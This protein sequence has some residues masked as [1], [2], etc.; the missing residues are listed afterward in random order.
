MLADLRT[1][2]VQSEVAPAIQSWHYVVELVSALKRPIG[3]ELKFLF[4]QSQQPEVSLSHAL[5][6]YNLLQVY[7]YLYLSDREELRR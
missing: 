4:F 5:L 3:D 1:N 2:R 7:I 6:T